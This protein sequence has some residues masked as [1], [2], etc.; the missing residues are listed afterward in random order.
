MPLD[1]LVVLPVERVVSFMWSLTLFIMR[2]TPSLELFIMLSLKSDHSGS[3]SEGQRSSSWNKSSLLQVIRPLMWGGANVEICNGAGI[4]V[5]YGKT[6]ICHGFQI[7]HIILAKGGKIRDGENHLGLRS[8]SD[9]SFGA[10]DS[11]NANEKIHVTVALNHFGKGLAERM[12]ST[13]HPTIISQGNRY[14]APGT[15]AAKEVTYRGIL[16]LVQ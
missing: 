15:F 9:V 13:S 4:P 7:H 2:L 1:L 8:A 3:L 6:V 12:P 14:S 16:K 5:Q 11:Y 10:S